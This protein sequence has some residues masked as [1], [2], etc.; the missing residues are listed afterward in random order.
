MKHKLL[1]LSLLISLSYSSILA[2]EAQHPIVKGYGGIYEIEDPVELVQP[3]KEYK[4]LIELVSENKNPEEHSFWIN[5]VARLMNLHG[6][7]GVPKENLKV[8]V[9]V[10]GP[11]V[12][13]ILSNGNYFEKF[14]IAK[15]PNIPVLEALDEAGAE[16]IVCGQS[17]LARE[18]ARDEIWS[19]TKVATSALTTISK[20]VSEGYVLFKF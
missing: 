13:D 6:I 2:Q 19:K 14:R 20:N 18:L 4:I 5:N 10:H 17:L 9:V 3:D 8:K 15:N 7:Q 11:A 12:L 16:V 1:I